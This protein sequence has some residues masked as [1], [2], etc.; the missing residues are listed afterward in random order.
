MSI[1]CLV[2]FD[3]LMTNELVARCLQNVHFLWQI[4]VGFLYC[5][6]LC[7]KRLYRYDLFVV[8]VE[9]VVVIDRLDSGSVRSDSDLVSVLVVGVGVVGLVGGFGSF[10]V[11]SSCS[12]FS[13]ALTSFFP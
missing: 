7:E 3:V 13:F 2:L 5:C 4:L 8:V 11:L 1:A 12:V 6:W 9:L 10:V